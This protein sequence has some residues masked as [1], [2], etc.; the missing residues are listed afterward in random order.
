M[1]DDSS[2]VNFTNVTL[3]DMFLAMSMKEVDR[4]TAEKAFNAFYYRYKDYL[5]SIVNK[6]CISWKMYG[7]DLVKDVFQNTFLSVYQKAESFLLIDDLPIENQEKRLK[8]WLGR[9]AQNEMFQLLRENS[10]EKIDYLEDLSIFNESSEENEII[11]SENVLLVEKALSNL[12]ERD[13]DILIT[14]IQFEE[15]NKKLP[16]DEISRLSEYWEVLPD[17]MRKIKQRALL[18]VKEYIETYKSNKL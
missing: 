15:G 1:K 8:A 5:F 10:K 14:Y 2:L 11:A 16:R 18:N 13:R 3:A 12:K 7:E 6:A 9:I 4:P 17:N